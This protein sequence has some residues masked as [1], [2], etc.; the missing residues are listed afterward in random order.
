MDWKRAE[1][2]WPLASRHVTQ[3]EHPEWPRQVAVAAAKAGAREDALRLWKIVTNI[4]PAHTA[5]LD[6]LVKAGLRD[7]L[8]ACYCDMQKR[9]PTSDAPRVALAALV[10]K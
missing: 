5:G 10:E 8:V 6:D 7:E 4:D 9:M 2:A 1:E 3:A